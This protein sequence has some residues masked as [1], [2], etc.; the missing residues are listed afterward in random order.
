[1]RQ[2][3]NLWVAVTLGL[4]AQLSAQSPSVPRPRQLPAVPGLAPR[5]YGAPTNAAD[6]LELTVAIFRAAIAHGTRTA[7]PAPLPRLVCLGR[8]GGWDEDPPIGVVDALQ[9]IDTLI[10]RPVSACRR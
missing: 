9:Q 7:Q 5:P 2:F 6:S 4:G 1:M 3:I 8:I 10:V